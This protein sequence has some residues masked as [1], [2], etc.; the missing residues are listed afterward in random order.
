MSFQYDKLPNNGFFRIFELKPGKDDDPLQGILRTFPRKEAPAYEALSYMWGSPD[1]VKHMECNEQK[2]MI[3]SSLDCALRRL[4]L[5]KESRYLWI[6]QICINQESPNE[7]SE[8]VGIMKD[9]YSGSVLVTAWLGQA[10]PGD[11]ADT[12]RMIS[13]LAAVKLQPSSCLPYFPENKRLQELGLPARESPGWGDLNS[14]LKAPYF[15][16]V[17]IIQELAVAPT[18]DL[19]WGDHLISKADFEAFQLSVV[20]LGMFYPDPDCLR[21]TSKSSSKGVYPNVEYVEWAV[22]MGS[23]GQAWKDKNLL[24]LV[25]EAKDCHATAGR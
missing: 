20:C 13:A 22:P 7:R 21:K 19:L 16:R 11:S 1:R 14:M 25:S 8:Q 3:T 10:D 6:D 5:A 24:E 15:S 23:S 4:R 17:W 2:F 18:Y 9:I 12:R